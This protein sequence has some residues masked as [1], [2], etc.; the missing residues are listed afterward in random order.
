MIYVFGKRT[1]TAYWVNVT[2]VEAMPRNRS[3]SY[4][5]SNLSCCYIADC[6]DPTAQHCSTRTHFLH[7]LLLLHD[8]QHVLRFIERNITHP[9]AGHCNAHGPSHPMGGMRHT[10][11]AAHAYITSH[12]MQNAMRP[13]STP[14]RIKGAVLAG[15]ALELTWCSQSPWFLQVMASTIPQHVR[16]SNTVLV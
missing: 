14:R 6:I 4:K 3:V 2:D 5:M 10:R 1:L 16:V 12:H 7:P 13:E 11:H 8:I 15:H 9:S